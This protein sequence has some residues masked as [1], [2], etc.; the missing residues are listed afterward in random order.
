VQDLC[1]A[2]YGL[3]FARE[4]LGARLDSRYCASHLLSAWDYARRAV[5][6]LAVPHVLAAWDQCFSAGRAAGRAAAAEPNPCPEGRPPQGGRYHP[7]R[8]P[9]GGRTWE[10]SAFG[11]YGAPTTP[12]E[13]RAERRF[14]AAVARAR[15]K[16]A[17]PAPRPA[18]LPDAP[19]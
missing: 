2:A 16:V 10:P 13:E 14:R 9:K 8:T 12:A 3:G 15:R 19:F 7:P 18:P 5:A 17:G 11:T 4:Y 1:D 6:G